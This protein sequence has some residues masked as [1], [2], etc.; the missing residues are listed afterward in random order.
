MNSGWEICSP[1]DS[2]IA[3]LHPRSMPIAPDSV[4]R[5][6]SQLTVIEAY[7]LPFLMMSY[8]NTVQNPNGGKQVENE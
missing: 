1:V 3:S 6:G 7:H 5:T 2:V 8:Q 4:E